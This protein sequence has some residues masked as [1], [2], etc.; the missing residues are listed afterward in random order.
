MRISDDATRAASEDS[1]PGSS[2]DSKRRMAIRWALMLTAVIIAIDTMPANITFVKPLKAILFPIL[3]SMGLSQGDWPLFAPNPILKNGT[4]VAE[5]MDRE[6]QQG[7]WTS[8]DW[9][10]ATAWEKFYRFRHMNYYQRVAQNHFASSDLADYLQ[11]AIPDKEH[12]VPAIRWSESNE[13]LPAVDLV[14]PM[15]E[16]K[17]YQYQQRMVLNEKNPMPNQ[18]QTVWSNKNRFLLRREYSK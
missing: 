15:V 7:T 10:R 13:L 8:P 5:V 1:T 4:I 14:P 18:P 11:R 17:L 6:L 16:V 3:G 12:A 2:H 9:A